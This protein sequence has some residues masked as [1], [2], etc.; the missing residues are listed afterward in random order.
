[1]GV[2][3]W[4]DKAQGRDGFSVTVFIGGNRDA[5]PQK[6]RNPKKGSEPSA[7]TQRQMRGGI[8][9]GPVSL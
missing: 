8:G 9:S 6:A 4:A 5:R 1:M 3:S 7:Q 2:P